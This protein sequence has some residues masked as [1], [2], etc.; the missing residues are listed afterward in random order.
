LAPQEGPGVY[1]GLISVP[2]TG[3]CTDTKEYPSGHFVQFGWKPMP[4][5]MEI[6]E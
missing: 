3:I 4:W 6:D 1:P 2:G 5:P